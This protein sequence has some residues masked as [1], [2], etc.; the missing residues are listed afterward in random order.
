[1]VVLCN[2]QTRISTSTS[3]VKFQSADLGWRKLF[4]S[5]CAEVMPARPVQ[6]LL[7]HNRELLVVE[8]NCGIVHWLNQK[9]KE[10]EAVGAA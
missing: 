10:K 8:R 1:M 6:E 3:L 2:D 9:K 7:S 4:T 5:A